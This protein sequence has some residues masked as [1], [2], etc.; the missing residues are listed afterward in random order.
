MGRGRSSSSSSSIESTSKSNPYGGSSNTRNLSTDL[1]LGLSFGASSGTQYF[2]G[3]YGYSVVDPSAD[4]TVAVAEEEEEEN[5]CNS[6]GSFYVKVNMEGVP[7]GRKIDLMSL[8]GYHELI[9]TL[10]FMFNASILWADDEE[11]CG[12]KSH[13]LTYADKEGDWMMVGDVPWE[14]FLSTVR[15]LKISRA[16]HY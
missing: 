15:R 9:R 6:V 8:N 5:E 14:M 12:Q 16:Y 7:I 1:R 3:G 11:M 10:D 4:Y 13:V 2:N